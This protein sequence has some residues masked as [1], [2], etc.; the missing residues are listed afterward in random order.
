MSIIA[1][2]FARA[3]PKTA[4]SQLLKAGKM[5]LIQR[6]LRK[7]RSAMKWREFAPFEDRIKSSEFAAFENLKGPNR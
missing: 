5:R 6:F 3:G 1:E 4:N 7:A 2:Y